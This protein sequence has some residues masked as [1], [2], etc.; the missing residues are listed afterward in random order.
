MR[1]NKGKVILALLFAAALCISVLVPVKTYAANPVYVALG[2]SIPAGYGLSNTKDAYP[3]ILAGEIHYTLYNQAHSGDTTSDLINKLKNVTDKSR[4]SQA[5]LVT[6]SI[7]G[8]DLMGSFENILT[9]LY[10]SD[11]VIDSIYAASIANLRT[12]CSTILTLVPKNCIILFHNIYNPYSGMGS[13]GALVGQRIGRENQQIKTVCDEY[14]RIHY[15]DVTSMNSNPNNFNAGSGSTFS[16]ILDCHPTNAGHSVLAGIVREA[17]YGAGG[18][19]NVTV[20]TQA[21]TNATTKKETS[22]T[23]TQVVHTTYVASQEST[24]NIVT[25][26]STSYITEEITTET[27]TEVTTEVTTEETTTVTTPVETTTETTAPETTTT[28][29]Y[30]TTEQ[31]TV[32]TT[33]LETTVPLE[34][35][36]AQESTTIPVSNEEVETTEKGTAEQTNETTTDVTTETETEEQKNTGSTNV[37]LV[38]VCLVGGIAVLV[39]AYFLMYY[40]FKYLLMKRKD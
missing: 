40:I 23:V 7:G 34:T 17:F 38:I 37:V 31:A 29:Q 24:T 1:K 25:Q 28:I 9:L 22:K 27:T 16:E 11:D 14:P 30:V 13:I 12:I 26:E 4:L 35:E 33:G 15:V 3:S 39:G 2:D 8:N 36:T 19:D 18:K 5:S 21:V 20:T 6:I 10:G 32:V